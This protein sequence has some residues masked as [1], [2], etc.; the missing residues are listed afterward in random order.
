MRF[1][2][3]TSSW[4][5][6]LLCAWFALTVPHIG[7]AQ[8]PLRVLTTVGMIADVARNVAGDCAEVQALMGSG[9]DP[10]LYR[11][12]A[13]DVNRLARAEL[14]FYVHP[15]LEAR[16]AEVLRDMRGRVPTV[17]LVDAA[18]AREE[19]LDDPDE[20]GAVDPHLWMDTSRWARIIPVISDA[21]IEQRPACAS[22]IRARAEA[23]TSQLAALH[24]WVTSAIGS[25]P[26]DRRMLVTA[27]DA[28]EYFGEAYGMEASEAIEGIS[29]ESEASIG[30]IRAVARFVVEN[31]IPAVFVETTI[32]PRT[33]E[34][35]VAEVR[36]KGH[37]VRIGGE[38]FSDAMGRQG[39]VEG[40]YIGMI[41][42][43]TM[44]ITEA[45][46]GEVPPWPNALSDWAHAW[47][48]A[49]SP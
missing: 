39:T 41:R 2:I 31:Q 42:H 34:A 49:P 14:I 24:D 33:I 27:H 9:S 30:D 38:L 11:A 12:S 1:K 13:S 47:G 17:G 40:T 4:A 43:N 23:Y 29:T 46:G 44:T 5:A 3:G 45:L 18:Y 7:S 15:A 16:L 28:F 8:E 32:N 19:L 35:L 26:E 6:P 37:D 22:D 25:I 21:V 20:P 10:H 48:L 36:S